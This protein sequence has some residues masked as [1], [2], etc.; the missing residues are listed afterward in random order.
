MNIDMNIEIKKYNC[1]TFL[2]EWYINNVNNNMTSKLFS[3]IQKPFGKIKL[4]LLLEEKPGLVKTPYT[5]LS[6]DVSVLLI[7]SEMYMKS[8]S[9]SS[10]NSLGVERIVLLISEDIACTREAGAIE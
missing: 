8:S 2:K 9:S 6:G 10:E 5:F 1:I 4:R 7:L 3:K